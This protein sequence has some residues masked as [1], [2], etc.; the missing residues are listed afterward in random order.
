[1]CK[2]R[3]YQLW[4]VQALLTS[5]SPHRECCSHTLCCKRGRSC[6]SWESCKEAS[7]GCHSKG[8][9]LTPEHCSVVHRLL[10]F[11]PNATLTPSAAQHQMPFPLPN[12]LLA[13]LLKCW[14]LL[15]P[16]TA[17]PAGFH[18]SVWHPW[19]SL[20]AQKNLLQ[21]LFHN[22]FFVVNESL[23]NCILIVELINLDFV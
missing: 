13:F 19:F 6:S 14:F 5:N 1:M 2:E 8:L 23:N 9:C 11:G 12:S 15:A 20:T 4:C 3:S 17:S 7:L 18:F 22:C 21:C 10:L 16:K